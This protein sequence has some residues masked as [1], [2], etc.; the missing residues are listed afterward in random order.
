[1]IR[2]VIRNKETNLLLLKFNSIIER[3]TNHKK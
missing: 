3:K 2:K 1:M